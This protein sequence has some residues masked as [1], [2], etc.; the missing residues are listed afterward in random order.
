MKSYDPAI[1]GYLQ[2]SGG[3]RSRLLAYVWAKRRV[4]NVIEGMG[5]W[6]GEQDRTFTIAGAPRDYYRAAGLIQID[7]LLF[8]PGTEVVFTE[9][10]LSGVDPA[11]RLMLGNYSLR[12][13]PVEIHR[14]LFWPEDG[15]LVGPPE[16]LLKGWIDQAP[17]ETPEVGGMAELRLSLASANLVLNRTLPFK[18]SGPALSAARSGDQFRRFTDVGAVSTPWGEARAPAFVTPFGPRGNG[19]YLPVV[20]S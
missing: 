12:Y 15:T 11:V 1:L 19:S 8:E 10:R 17:I 9:F 7:E 3:K 18:K 4:D 13:A 2:A 20:D 5:L 6:S 16:R 14:A